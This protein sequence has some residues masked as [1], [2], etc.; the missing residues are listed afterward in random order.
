M[1][2]I[3]LIDKFNKSAKGKIIRSIFVFLMSGI[4]VATVCVAYAWFAINK[5]TDSSGLQITTTVDE[6]SAVFSSYYIHDLDTKAV[7]KGTQY[8][9][10]NGVTT[11]DIDMINF[12]MTFTS[13][14]QYA[15]VVVRIQIYDIP[16]RFVPSSG[17]TK[18]ISLIFTRNTSVS[19][20]TDD[21]L[22]IYFSSVGQLGC[23]TNSSLALNATNKT[24]YD[25][26]LAQYRADNN[27]MRFTTY[28]STTELYTKVGFLDRSVPYTSADFK[29]DSNSE[30]CLVLYVCFDYYDVFAQ[31]FADQS[32]EGL[33]SGGLEQKYDMVNDITSITVDFN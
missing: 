13:T 19:F 22:D 23:Y 3:K 33:G 6:I 21:E 17:Q 7:E 30:T 31:A 28:N 1:N 8:T 14:N 15:P 27:I 10:G 24:I 29:T 25:T 12:D 2:L 20:T 5:Q 11:L 26:V 32:N 9:D 18:Y 16:S 4:M